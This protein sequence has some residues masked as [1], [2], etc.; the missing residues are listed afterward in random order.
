MKKYVK[1]TERPFEGHEFKKSLGQNFLR[2]TNLLAG[3]VRDSG[4]SADDIVVEVGAG[5]GTLTEQITKVARVV[6]S[7]E[8]D[9]SLEEILRNK[10]SE[11]ENLKIVFRD[12]LKTPDDEICGEISDFL[13][14]IGQNSE[15]STYKVVANIPYYITTP[16]IFKFLKSDRVSSITIMVQKEVAERVVSKA[17]TGEYGALSVMVN[18]YG[19]ATIKRI[20]D[21]SMFYPSPKVDSAILRID[22]DEN[23]DV[24]I[25]DALAEV[26][27]SAFSARRKM[28]ANNL[29]EEFGIS[30]DCFHKLFEEM[31]LKSTVRAEELSV[32][33]FIQLSKKIENLR[34]IKTNV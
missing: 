2:D 17:S 19:K 18:Y 1:T 7:F 24:R 30:K 26:V 11:N 33:Q 34:Q 13:L 25:G 23:R 3:I 6:V 29:S 20:V 27:K 10:E 4:V 5:A 9:R 31:G 16:L 21:K 8:V 22:K 12:A 14:K 15:F 28:L 32:E